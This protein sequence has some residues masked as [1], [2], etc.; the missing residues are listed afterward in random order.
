MAGVEQSVYARGQQSCGR[1]GTVWMQKQQPHPKTPSDTSLRIEAPVRGLVPDPQAK[2]SVDRAIL[3][4]PKSAVPAATA[5]YSPPRH[6]QREGD[7]GGSGGQE[8]RR[9][10]TLG[11]SHIHIYMIPF[12]NEHQQHNDSA[13]MHLLIILIYPP[14]CGT[15]HGIGIAVGHCDRAVVPSVALHD[16]QSD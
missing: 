13:G 1:R 12:N 2:A 16:G 5:T 4:V 14:M 11:K 8:V 6:K 15:N 9:I 10:A 7:W 3:P